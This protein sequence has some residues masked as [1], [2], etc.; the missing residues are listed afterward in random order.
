MQSLAGTDL[1]VRLEGDV[2]ADHVVKEDAQGPDGGACTLVPVK[3]DPFRRGIDTGSCK[4]I[5]IV[6][7]MN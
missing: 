7:L 5:E 3:G 6:N 2:A 1:F 4:T